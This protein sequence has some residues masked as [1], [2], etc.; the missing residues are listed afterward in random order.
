MNTVHYV[1]SSIHFWSYF[2]EHV[3][4]SSFFNIF[5]GREGI[6][7]RKSNTSSSELLQTVVWNCSARALLKQTHYL[8]FNHFLCSEPLLHFCLFLC[9]IYNPKCINTALTCNSM[10]PKAGSD[11][12]PTVV[13]RF[14]LIFRHLSVQKKG[15]T[16]LWGYQKN[17]LGR[18]RCTN[19]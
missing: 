16:P 19:I 12:V 13:L 14:P 18:K 9:C 10:F 17:A 11:S 7:V 15:W 3:I 1:Y 4:K 8:C 6:S 2:Q 5:G